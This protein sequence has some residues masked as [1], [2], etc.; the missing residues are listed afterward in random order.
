MAGPPTGKTDLSCCGPALYCCPNSSSHITSYNPV[1]R[2]THKHI[3][4]FPQSFNKFFVI[5]TRLFLMHHIL[6][7]MTTRP[8][9]NAHKPP[10]ATQRCCQPCTRLVAVILN[11][12]EADK[13]AIENGL[14]SGQLV[15]CRFGARWVI[16]C[17]CCEM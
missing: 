13:G 11:R 10:S 3:P 8:L 15:S 14:H 9:Q 7:L 1:P 2:L 5:C 12:D 16:H 17:R 6:H 4:L